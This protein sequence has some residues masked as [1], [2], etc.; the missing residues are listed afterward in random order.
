M[1][2]GVAVESVG[3][4]A[5]AFPVAP[6]DPA[7]REVGAPGF[8]FAQ[9]SPG[10]IAIFDEEFGS[11]QNLTEHGC[12]EALLVAVGSRQD[13]CQLSQNR[14]ADVSRRL[15]RASVF[16]EA[17]RSLRLLG[18]VLSDVTH[19]NVGVENENRGIAVRASYALVRAYMR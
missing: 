1:P 2:G 17:C 19:K 3:R 7:I 16:D 14:N 13:P 12:D 9:R 11:S 18:I 15:R 4:R 8:E 10:R 6:G 5:T